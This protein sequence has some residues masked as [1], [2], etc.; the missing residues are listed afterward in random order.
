MIE[1]LRRFLVGEIQPL[2]HPVLDERERHLDEILARVSGRSVEDV[3][4]DARRRALQ[5]E[6]Q[7]MRRR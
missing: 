2:Q 3:Q 5:I 1:K 7:S 4:R 6:V